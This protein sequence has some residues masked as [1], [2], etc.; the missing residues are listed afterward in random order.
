MYAEEKKNKGGISAR[1]VTDLVIAEFG[2]SPIARYIQRYIKYGIV[3]Q[4]PAQNK[5]SE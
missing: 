3:G 4:T 2:V 1:K 5:P